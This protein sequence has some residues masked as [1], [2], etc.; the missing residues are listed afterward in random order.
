MYGKYWSELP[1][2]RAEFGQGSFPRLHFRN[3]PV[4]QSRDGTILARLCAAHSIINNI[5]FIEEKKQGG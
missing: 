2:C 3:K 5:G 1:I 4:F